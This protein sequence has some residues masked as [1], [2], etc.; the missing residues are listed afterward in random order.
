MLCTRCERRAQFLETGRR[1]RYECGDL[2]IDKQTCYAYL[3]VKP[4]I[5]QKHTNDKVLE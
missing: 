5:L 1:L 3:P 4:A 2:T